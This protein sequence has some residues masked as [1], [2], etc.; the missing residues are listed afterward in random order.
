LRRHQQKKALSATDKDEMKE[1][2]R[3]ARTAADLGGDRS[4]GQAKMLLGS[5]YLEG[6]GVAQNDAKAFEWFHKAAEQGLAEAQFKTAALLFEGKNGLAR[7]TDEAALWYRRAADQGHERGQLNTAVILYDRSDVEGAV[8][9]FEMA[10]A[11]GNVE[12]HFRLGDIYSQGRGTVKVDK[13]LAKSLY[14]LAANKDHA[15]A[16]RSLAILHHTG[17]GT[18]QNHAEAAR[19]Y[20]KAARRDAVAARGLGLLFASGCGVPK[21][22]AEAVRCWRMAAEKGDAKAQ[23]FLGIAIWN[24]KG[25]LRRNPTEAANWLRA[26][27]AQ[28]KIESAEA[29]VHLGL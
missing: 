26:A 4:C 7:N 25:V 21:S 23:H 5:I 29:I 11:Q 10:A 8:K 20:Q 14:E 15:G 24:G 18:P 13:T 3:L 16:Q 12:A 6:K 2:L 22:D 28:G 1:V 27:A 19:W 17:Q 9:W